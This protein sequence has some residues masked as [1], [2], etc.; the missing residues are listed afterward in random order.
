MIHIPEENQVQLDQLLT[1]GMMLS[2]WKLSEPYAALQDWPPGNALRLAARI[3]SGAGNE[4]LATAL[5]WKNW[6]H[7]RLDPE[8]AFW[9]MFARLRFKPPVTLLPE[10]DGWLATS[11]MSDRLRS[12]YLALKAWSLATLRD[13]TPARASIK[14]ALVM[15]PDDSWTHVQHSQVLEMEDCYEDALAAAMRAVELRPG[16]RSAVVQA[17]E[18]LIYLNR[19]DDAIDLLRRTHQQ[20]ENGAF[21]MRLQGL[22]SE[23]EEHQDGLRCLDEIERLMPLMPETTRQWLAGRRADFLYMAGDIDGCLE[24]SAHTKKSGYRQKV[25]VNLQRPDARARKRKRLEVP[26]I[27]QHNMTCAPAT[28]AALAKYWRRDHDHLDIAAA[29]CD[30]GTPWHKERG[31]AEAHGFIAREFRF[32]REILISLID[33]GIPF[34]LTTSWVTGAHLQACIG[35]DDRQGTAILRDPTHRHFGEA[36]IEDLILEH[37]LHGPRCMLLLPHE[38][39]SRLEGLV[40]PDEAYHDA[41]HQMAQAIENHDRWAAE[42]AVSTLRA[43]DS[44]H[45]LTLS[46]ESHFANYLG[47]HEKS[48]AI[49]TRLSKRFPDHQPLHFLRVRVMQQLGEQ[50]PLRQLLEHQVG[51][52]NADPAF[53]SAL[54]DLLLEDARQLPLAGYFLRRCAR[55][56]RGEGRFQ[57]SLARHAIKRGDFTEAARLR[58]FACLLST[59]WEPYAIACFESFRLIGKTGEGID[60]LRERTRTGRQKK[61]APWL[62][63]AQAFD[64]LHQHHDARATLEKAIRLLPDDGELRLKAGRIMIFWGKDDRRRGLEWI[65]QAKGK[66]A[67][68]LWLREKAWTEGALG[69][70]NSAIHFWKALLAREPLAI[71]AYRSLARLI[72]EES[73]KAE[74]IRFLTESAERNPR[75]PGLWLA[76]ADWLAGERP[77]ADLPALH[78]ALELDPDDNWTLR[79]RAGKRFAAGDKPGG[80]EDA[81]KA[82]ER[83]PMS[84]ESHG[85]LASLLHQSGEKARALDCLRESLRLRIDYVYALE[86]F[87]R[88]SQGSSSAR[89]TLAFIEAEMNRQVSNG[90]CVLPYQQAAWSVIP[91]EELLANLRVFCAQRPDL[92]QTWSAR[93]D[94]CLGMDRLA[95]ARECADQLKKSFPLLAR[96]WIEAAKVEKADGDHQAQA[97]ALRTAVDLSPAWDW[98]V[99]QLGEVLE[100]IGHYD[101]ARAVLERAINYDPLNGPNHGCLADLLYKMNRKDEAFA[102]LLAAMDICPFYKWG[103]T[104]LGGW[105]NTPERLAKLEEKVQLQCERLSHNAEWWAIAADIWLSLSRHE[106]ALKA[107]QA[108]LEVAPDH[109]ELRDQLASILCGMGHFDEALEACMPASGPPTRELQGRRAWVLME[110]G[111][112]PAA[113]AAMKSVLDLEADYTWGWHQ[114]ATWHFVRSDWSKLA[115]AVGQWVRLAPDSSIAHGHVGLAA[116]EL[117]ETQKAKH[118]FERAFRMDPEYQYAGR[119]LLKLQ[120]ADRDFAAARNTLATL[121]HYAPGPLLDCEAVKLS[122]A[123]RNDTDAFSLAGEMHLS[124][125]YPDALILLQAE[126]EKHG[127]AKHWRDQCET[128]IK[129]GKAVS[130]AALAAWAAFFKSPADLAKAVKRMHKFAISEEARNAAWNILL[131]ATQSS[132][133]PELLP[134][135]IRRHHARFAES[136]DLWNTVGQLLLLT[137]KRKETVEWFAGWQQRETDVGA[138]TL[139]N[140]TAALDHVSGPKASEEVRAAGIARF[141]TDENALYLRAGQASYFA[142]NGRLDEARQ[143]LAPIE[144]SRVNNFYLGLASL[145]RSI[146]AA[147][148]NNEEEA[149]RHYRIGIDNLKILT[150]DQ[151]VKKHVIPAQQ[152]LASYLP[153]AAGKRHR[154]AKHWGTLPGCSPWQ[155]F[156]KVLLITL[157]IVAALGV[158]GLLL[159]GG[160]SPVI[161]F[162][163]LAFLAR[164]LMNNK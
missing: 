98:A 108:G 10:I 67:E 28:L 23:R 85:V 93:I 162:L 118:A 87:I 68:T 57:E 115:E 55:Q 136:G 153:W 132:G 137:G 144:D 125:T 152:A 69:N 7:D 56:Q 164:S 117:G 65:D 154:V 83:A 19:D 104:S 119:E 74:S 134:K 12:D 24:S 133:D 79:Q 31:W 53:V 103:W 88:W 41:Y 157:G 145:G 5:D 13:F 109:L 126:F 81:Q 35:Y 26:F 130:P 150:G 38:E 59:G 89:E 72:A 52:K 112:G 14:E 54:G 102:G 50:T 140:L 75:Q 116:L 160:V 43:L 61:S 11:G 2:A 113:I 135:W 70:R 77:G 45:P 97:A 25:A 123:E 40:L 63:L 8:R 3:S 149:K 58:R 29:I 37:P 27:R 60:F 6:R 151:S 1:R 138:H 21:M 32:G 73:G 106:E 84:P 121:R 94:Q 34:T 76:L 18:C 36:L 78:R 120:V 17:V 39:A 147:S 141:R 148:E 49:L 127:Y 143:M 163:V 91:P 33:R 16:Y 101:E 80:L 44:D 129:N 96:T 100:R 90:D 82:L 95:E 139:V 124:A 114:L 111:D 51:L 161:P 9:A 20:V 71:D 128:R 146:I 64:S 110:S 99:R 156:A 22:H 42:T 159:I 92:W 62:T 107:V 86:H 155:N 48:H 47:H 142:A 30:E 66:V 46:G 15:T 122:L 131:R 158:L 4:R 105:S